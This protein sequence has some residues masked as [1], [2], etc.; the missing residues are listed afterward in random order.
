MNKIVLIQGT[1]GSG[2]STTVSKILNQF[3]N[4]PIYG[5]LGPRYPEAYKVDL[6]L[7]EPLF[8]L[9]PYQHGRSGGADHFKGF[10]S[11]IH[12]LNKYN[13]KG[14][15]LFECIIMAGVHGKVGTYMEQL[16]K[17][18]AICFMDTPLEICIERVLAR[19]QLIGNDKEFNPTNLTNKF[20]AILSLR[21]RSIAHGKISVLDI[22]CDEGPN[23]ILEYLAKEHEHV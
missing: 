17:D 5:I 20:Q 11:V 21:S 9:G 19:R 14:H 12:L 1:N 23:Q 18:A 10:E 2:K 8:I 3:P 15:V 16:G 7:A 22:S 4:K 13:P 6:P